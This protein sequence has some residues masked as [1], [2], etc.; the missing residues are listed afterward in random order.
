[1]THQ[2]VHQFGQPRSQTQ[3]TTSRFA[4]HSLTVQAQRD[5]DRPRTH[6]S[7]VQMQGLEQAARFGHHFAS[8]PVYPPEA[9]ASTPVQRKH[10]TD[11]EP[12]ASTE[13]RPNHTGLPAHLKAG[14]ENLS[15]FSLDNVKVHYN[16]NKPAQ[17]NALA[18]TQGTEIHVA[19]GQE[20]HLAHEAWHVVQQAQGRVKP[21]MQLKGEVPVNDDEGLEREADVMGEKARTIKDV[22][23]TGDSNQEDTIPSSSAPQPT[24]SGVVQ[25]RVGFEF[26]DTYWRPWKRETTFSA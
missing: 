12:A 16:S 1:M 3:Q 4:A 14:I 11:D 6:L 23:R 22:A 24:I 13:Q 9:P 15:G 20:R 10:M 7:D 18:Y 2:R 17:V 25:R 19:P 8:I 26:E 21:T 5:A